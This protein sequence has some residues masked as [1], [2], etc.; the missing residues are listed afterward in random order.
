[1][2][3]NPFGQQDESLVCFFVVDGRWQHSRRS[4][5]SGIILLGIL[6]RPSWLLVFGLPMMTRVPLASLLSSRRRSSKGTHNARNYHSFYIFGHC[7]KKLCF[8]MQL[9]ILVPHGPLVFLTIGLGF[10]ED[11]VS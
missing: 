9:S 1:L 4:L 7:V 3:Q 11:L 8:T 6:D 2:V 5:P 10:R